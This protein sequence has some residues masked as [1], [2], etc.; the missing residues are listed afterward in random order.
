MSGAR[1][2][3]TQKK[4]TSV[5]VLPGVAHW[6]VR[7]IVAPKHGRGVST[8]VPEPGKVASQSWVPLPGV[9]E[10]N[11]WFEQRPSIGLVQVLSASQMPSSQA[12][13][14]FWLGQKHCP[15][16]PTDTHGWSAVCLMVPVVSGER[17]IVSSPTLLPDGRQ[18]F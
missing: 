5:P 4:D 2:A 3:G 17:T 13:G 9:Q 14:R 10:R 6:P 12:F 15:T 16:E 11:F 18:S 7:L 8:H 1:V